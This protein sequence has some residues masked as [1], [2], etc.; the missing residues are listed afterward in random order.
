VVLIFEQISITREVAC[1]LYEKMW[2]LDE[3]K[4]AFSSYGQYVSK[5]IL[6]LDFRFF[7]R[8]GIKLVDTAATGLKVPALAKRISIRSPEGLFYEMVEPFPDE[9]SLLFEPVQNT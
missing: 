9:Y 5:F 7:T 3:C 1:G 2:I 4:A 6:S 8:T